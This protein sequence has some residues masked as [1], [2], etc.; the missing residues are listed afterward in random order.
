MELWETKKKE[1]S[2]LKGWYWKSV[3]ICTNTIR[4]FHSSFQF[5]KLIIGIP[6]SRIMSAVI[7]FP[8]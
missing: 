6:A 5:Y 4:H 1:K 7:E 8:E 3:G 2:I